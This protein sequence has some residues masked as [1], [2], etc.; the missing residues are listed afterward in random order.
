MDVIDLVQTK[1][2]API[3]IALKKDLALRFFVNYSNMNAIT[4]QGFCPILGIDESIESL[5][6]ATVFSTLD[7]NIRYFQV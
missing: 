3:M 5:A 6:D 2:A 4:I 1:W 7:A